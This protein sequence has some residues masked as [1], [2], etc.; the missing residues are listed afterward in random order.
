MLTE[1]HQYFPFVPRYLGW[2]RDIV[3][4]ALSL[5]MEYFSCHQSLDIGQINTCI[6]SVRPI[7]YQSTE[8]T[9]WKIAQRILESKWWKLRA[10]RVLTIWVRRMKTSYSANIWSWCDDSQDYWE[11]NLFCIHCPAAGGGKSLYLSTDYFSS[12]PSQ[13]QS[14]PYFQGLKNNQ[15]KIYDNDLAPPL[16]PC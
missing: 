1:D 3:N 11:S 8:P 13:S 6:M 4:D 12:S 7:L 16:P 15:A 5:S 14:V 10:E 2:C 9:K